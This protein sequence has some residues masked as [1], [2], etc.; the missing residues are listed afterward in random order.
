MEE[1]K[2]FKEREQEM[3]EIIS[4]I[5]VNNV[6][7]K[8]QKNISINDSPIRLVDFKKNEASA[9]IRLYKDN[10]E[11]YDNLNPSIIN[12]GEYDAEI[13]PNIENFVNIRLNKIKLAD[14]LSMGLEKLD[15]APSIKDRKS[16]EDFTR[17]SVQHR[18]M[19]HTDSDMI[20][21][22]CP[23]CKTRYPFNIGKPFGVEAVVNFIMEIYDRSEAVKTAL[24]MMLKESING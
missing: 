5:V 15:A 12:E 10:I 4:K 2:L 22:E 23:K 18:L 3:K 24:L 14:N 20:I 16:V 19:Q 17:I 7:V 8:V 1:E 21:H 13:Q 9:R 11:V 6:E